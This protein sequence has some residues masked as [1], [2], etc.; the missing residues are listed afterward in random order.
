MKFLKNKI[1]LIV[2]LLVVI[3]IVLILF[4][5]QRDNKSKIEGVIGN[6]LTPIQKILYS[7]SKN[8]SDAYKGIVNRSELVGK[9]EDLIKENGE[10]KTKINLYDQL[11]FENDRL[12]EILNFKNKFS[13]Y[14]FV[15]ANIIGKNGSYINEVIID[16][17]AKDGL[18]SG[19]IVIANGGLFGM[20]TS[21]SDSW[22]L[23]SPLINGNIA[24]SG[25]IL[26][27]NMGQGIVKGNVSDE[28]NL[29]MEYLFADED[30]KIDDIVVTSGLGGVYPADIPIGEVVNIESDKRNLSKSVFIKS[31]VE[32]DFVKELFVVIPKDLNEIKY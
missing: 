30:V 29:K 25:I 17:G 13:N 16:I 15:G 7:V 24:V 19:M 14:K 32:F 9:I 5:S 6:T 18:K 11:K 31:H 21:I 23:V 10:L 20:V 26:R 22:S 4:S 28:Y 12:R 1:N 27:T 2:S 8:I 3:M